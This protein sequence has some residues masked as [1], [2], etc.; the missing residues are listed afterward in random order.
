MSLEVKVQVIKD[1]VLFGTTQKITD[2]VVLMNGVS[3][4]VKFAVARGVNLILD[5][6]IKMNPTYP[7]SKVEYVRIEN[8]KPVEFFE[9]GEI[10][11][12]TESDESSIVLEEEL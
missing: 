6:I 3:A 8:G 10:L 7:R 11:P 9:P 1:D 12:V 2:G 4:A 5:D